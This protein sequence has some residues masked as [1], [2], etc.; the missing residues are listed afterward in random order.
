MFTTPIGRRIGLEMVKMHAHACHRG[1]HQRGG[2]Q[3][4]IIRGLWKALHEEVPALH[5]RATSASARSLVCHSILVLLSQ[6]RPSVSTMARFR[7]YV[8]DSEEEEEDVSMEVQPQKAPPVA[9]NPDRDEDD[10]MDEDDLR[11]VVRPQA[12]YEENSS[13]EDEEEDE[14]EEAEEAEEEGESESESDEEDVRRRGGRRA[15]PNVARVARQGDPTIIP[16]AREIGVDPQR[17][18]VMQTSLFRMPEEEQVLKA[19][20]EPQ[21]RRKLPNLKSTLNRKH[22]RDSE[23]DG[24]RADSRQVC[25]NYFRARG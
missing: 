2:V 16:W 5:R 23:G 1:E 21:P 3:E 8:T 14:E 20:N 19:L 10:S 6:R 17:M 9:R 18:H 4:L 13:D 25:L 11:A 24:L 12:T 22:S 7:A 15:Q